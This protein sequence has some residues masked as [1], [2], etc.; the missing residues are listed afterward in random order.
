M[1]IQQEIRER[2]DCGRCG[3]PRCAH[4]WYIDRFIC[5]NCLIECNQIIQEKKREEEKII[6][7]L[8]GLK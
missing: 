5:L 6:K 8:V 4:V 2:P 3:R 1:R 7:E